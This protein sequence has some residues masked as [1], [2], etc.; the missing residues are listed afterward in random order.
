MVQQKGAEDGDHKAT[1]HTRSGAQH[2][3]AGGPPVPMSDCTVS[4]RFPLLHI[5][6]KFD[7][8]IILRHQV[9]PQQRLECE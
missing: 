5:D 4:S 6:L 1:L 9:Y 8:N 3:P 7:Q 2:V